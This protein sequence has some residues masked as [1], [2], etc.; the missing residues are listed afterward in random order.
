MNE[1]RSIGTLIVEPHADDAFLSLGAHIEEWVKAGRSV[2]ILTVYSATR[3]RGKDAKAY[4]DAVGAHWIGM[5]LE[6]MGQAREFGAAPCNIPNFV[7]VTLQAADN[8]ILPLGVGGH[9]EHHEV[10]EKFQNLYGGSKVLFYVDMPYACKL[11]NADDLHVRTRDKT[12][13]SVR[14]PGA[15]KWRHIPLFKDQAKFFH[16]NPAEDLA[17]TFELIVY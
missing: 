6:E 10:T 9:P 13:Y 5:G 8:V 1:P 2:T 14:K 17:K 12:V 3:S 4:A 15:R 7:A 16:F 11:K